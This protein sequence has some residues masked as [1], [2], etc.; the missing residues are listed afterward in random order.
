[1]ILR[2]LFHAQAPTLE[3]REGR[4]TTNYL[5][6]RHVDIST[7]VSYFNVGLAS[8]HHFYNVYLYWI[9]TNYKINNL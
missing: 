4:T 5:L 1:M 6:N 9:C 8:V 2:C 7:V 3:G